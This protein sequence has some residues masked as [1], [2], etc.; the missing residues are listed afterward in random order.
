[1]NYLFL[2]IVKQNAID[3]ELNKLTIKS[4]SKKNTDSQNNKRG[5]EGYKCDILDINI[6][7]SNMTCLE[8]KQQNVVCN[9]CKRYK[10]CK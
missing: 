3:C 8:F 6:S 7:D 1:M 4:S 10:N 9:Q 5:K 2:D